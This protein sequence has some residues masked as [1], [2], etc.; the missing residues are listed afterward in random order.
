MNRWEGSVIEV[1]RLVR[2]SAII[3][4]FDSNAESREQRIL[5]KERNTDSDIDFGKIFKS[6]C[7]DL[8]STG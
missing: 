8:K 6:A 1:E 4:M 2:V 3:E 5:K 7:E